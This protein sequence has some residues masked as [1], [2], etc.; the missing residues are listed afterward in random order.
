MTLVRHST[1]RPELASDA[2]YPERGV[3]GFFQAQ[4][5]SSFNLC[6]YVKAV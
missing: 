2:V 1:M 4:D 5:S 3:A 6:L